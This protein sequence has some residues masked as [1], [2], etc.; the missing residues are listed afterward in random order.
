MSRVFFPAIVE[1][2]SSGYGVFFPDLPGCTSAGGTV[3]QAARNAEEALRGHLRLMIED[4][5]P[6]P[7]P[8]E[9]D[10]V[11]QDP[12][13]VEAARVLVPAEV[14]SSKVIRLNITLPEDLVEQMDLYAQTQGLSRSGL[15]A[16]AA[17]RMIGA[18]GAAGG[19]RRHRQ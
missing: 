6:V 9:L 16:E 11:E 12:D 4:G 8:S 19:P 18:G 2:G 3:Q 15:I 17:R 5:D 10:A 13:V 1:K 7:V 14:P